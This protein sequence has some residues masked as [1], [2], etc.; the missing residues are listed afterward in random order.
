MEQEALTQP[1]A[2]EQVRSKVYRNL[3]ELG[4][5]PTELDVET[6]QML[7]DRSF[8]EDYGTAFAVDPHPLD[9]EIS[10]IVYKQHEQFSTSEVKISY[11]VDDSGI[12]IVVINPLTQ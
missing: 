3:I 6:L 10:K 11:G 2:I 8:L 1:D 9:A 4:L 12:S 5:E 7:S